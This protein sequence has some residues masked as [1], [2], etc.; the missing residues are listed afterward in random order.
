MDCLEEFK[1]LYPQSEVTPNIIIY[2]PRIWEMFETWVE[3]SGIDFYES[4]RISD[5]KMNP[6]DWYQ[7]SGFAYERM[8]QFL[9][10]M[11]SSD[12]HTVEI[13]RQEIPKGWPKLH[14]P[15]HRCEY[16][17]A[18]GSVVWDAYEAFRFGFDRKAEDGLRRHLRTLKISREI[19]QHAYSHG[20]DLQEL[21]TLCFWAIGQFVAH[22]ERNYDAD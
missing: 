7:R 16:M 22:Q 4:S 9:V 20:C 10:F 1:E 15:V 14:H 5:Y 11:Q 2:N 13:N 6:V 18:E 3:E 17:F 21:Y 8:T 12:I 19:V